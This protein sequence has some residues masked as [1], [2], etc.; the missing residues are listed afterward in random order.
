MLA[1]LVALSF[2][3][4]TTYY[5]R[6]E[7]ND[8]NSGKTP[9]SAWRTLD[10]ASKQAYASGDRL[11]L[12][13]GVTFPGTLAPKL[14]TVGFQVQ[15]FGNGVATV[16]SGA[17]SAI[18]LRSARNVR[19]SHIAVHGSGRDT[20]DG[21]G[22]EIVDS[23][24]V[25]VAD[26]SASGFRKEGVGVIGCTGVTLEG[27]SAVANG[28]AGIAAYGL[29]GRRN[30]DLTIRASRALENPG[31]PK[32]LHNHSG[33]GIVVGNV[34]GCLIDRCEAA[35]NGWGM[36][37]KGNGPVGIWAWDAS[38]VIVQRCISHH[39]LSPGLDGGGF[40][41]DG[42]VTD[43]ILRYNL[44]FANAGTGLL[45]CQYPNGARWAN[46]L[47]HDNVSYKDGSQNTQAG[48]ALYIV[49]GMTNMEGCRVER[50][51]IV[52][53]WHAVSTMGDI[54]QV[55]YAGNVFICGGAV[56]QDGWQGA[57]RGSEF[58]RNLAWGLGG[59]PRF[60]GA[61]PLMSEDAW[62]QRCG[63]I[64]DPK[65]DMP[66]SL[67]DLPTDPSKLADMRWF[68]PLKGSPCVV[69][70]SVVFGAQLKEARRLR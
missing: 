36:P 19:V 48:V 22:I 66:S 23:T 60:A 53:D 35:R 45:L 39:N 42:G 13:G 67:N 46:N 62:K 54:P 29:T 1:A 64:G 10:R 24:D 17:E 37:R 9:A 61:E 69:A 65:L 3:V 8:A 40:D 51:T 41:L 31:D 38:H 55:H 30:K 58:G 20:N 2:H 26:V 16:D 50:N 12:E 27:V 57:F 63:L 7:G 34:D 25:V 11:L 33:N 15:S 5:L 4:P 52:N 68:R 59:P 14:E 18:I 47:V 43:S 28:G 21:T 49:K 70:R 44:S 32:N 56:F 6:A